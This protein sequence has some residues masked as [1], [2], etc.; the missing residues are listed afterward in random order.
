MR[1]VVLAD[2]CHSGTILDVT[3]PIWRGQ[4]ALS[5]TGCK[6]KETSAGT[7]KG[8]QFTRAM[9]RAIEALQEEQED[10]YM[11][12]RLYN[13]TL[14]E[15]NEFKLPSHTQ[16]IT[17]HGCGTLPQ[18]FAWP[19]QPEGPY[20]SIANTIYRDMELEDLEG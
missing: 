6:D 14:Q 11:T 2:C 9:T 10:G 4:H 17:L 12:S 5:I 16:T 7:G 3:K 18:E 19:L 15:Y 8:G 20:V 1:V 13:R